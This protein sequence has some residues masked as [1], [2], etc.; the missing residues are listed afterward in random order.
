MIQDQERRMR[1][2]EECGVLD[3]LFEE[4]IDED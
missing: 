2:E 3:E 1:N 4:D